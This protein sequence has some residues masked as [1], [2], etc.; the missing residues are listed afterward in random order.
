[1]R[2][3]KPKELK[4]NILLLMSII[5]IMLLLFE[6]FFRL[7]NP[8]LTYEQAIISSPSVFAKS[9]YLPWQL[10]PFASDVHI[11]QFDEFRVNVTINSLGMRD[12]E[13]NIPKKGVKRILTLGDSFTYGYGVELNESYPKILE[14][15]LNK[16]QDGQKYIVLNAGYASGYSPDTYYLYLKKEGL[17]LQPD[18]IMVGFTTN[19]DVVDLF[20]NR[21][22]EGNGSAKIVSD[23]YYVDEDD[24]L[25]VP[26][27]NKQ[28]GLNVFLST[29]S[30]F[31]IFIKNSIGEI[32]QKQYGKNDVYKVEYDEGLKEKWGEVEKLLV[33]MNKLAEENNAK[34][35]VALIPRKAQVYDRYWEVY[36]NTHGDYEVDRTKPQKLLMNMCNKTSI[37]CIDLLPAFKEE[38]KEEFYFEKDGHWTKYGHRFAAEYL[39]EYI[40]K[41]TS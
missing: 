30:H 4:K 1:M 39:K 21:V 32:L 35:I 13:R 40:L 12:Y 8:Q 25:R 27:Y 26:S 23:S 10:K 38:A 18:I 29:H 41:E 17:K 7:F 3:I 37:R 22:I 24:R 36:K 33:K 20:K 28:S 2:K 31:F 19:N 16:N 6:G 11:S 34:L 14:Q 9:D 5:L 15:E